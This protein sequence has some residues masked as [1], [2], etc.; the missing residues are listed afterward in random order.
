MAADQDTIRA[1][2]AVGEDPSAG[3]SSDGDSGAEATHASEPEYPEVN[4]ADIGALFADSHETPE[5]FLIADRELQPQRAHFADN[6]SYLVELVPWVLYGDDYSEDPFLG[7]NPP[8]EIEECFVDAFVEAFPG[9]R[10]DE[11]VKA[12]DGTDLSEGIP[13]DVMAGRDTAVMMAAVPVPS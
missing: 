11:L 8:K 3:N 4:A 10:L 6:R 1:A 2:D 7:P 5:G 13:S 9:P 12:L